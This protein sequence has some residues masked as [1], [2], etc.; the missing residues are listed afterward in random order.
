MFYMLVRAGKIRTYKLGKMTFVAAEDAEA[1]Q[2]E[3]RR[4]GTGAG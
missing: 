1:W 3:A 2:K 4:G